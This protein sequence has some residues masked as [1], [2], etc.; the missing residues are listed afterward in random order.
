M[1]DRDD[2]TLLTEAARVAGR[3]AMSFWRA[4]PKAWEKSDGAGPV[5][6]ADMAVNAAVEDVL[7]HARPDYGWLSEESTDGPGR[8]QSG[9]VF[10]IDPIDGTRA[11]I[12]QSADFAHSFAVAEAGKVRAAVVFLP[13]R[14]LLYTATAGG[15]ALLNGAPIRVQP[16]TEVLTNKPAMAAA[17]WRDGAVPFRRAFRSSLAWRLALVAEGRF[18]GALTLRPTWEWDIAAGALLVESAG[19][20]VSDRQGAPLCF[21]RADPRLDGVIAAAP[22]MYHAIHDGLMTEPDRSKDRT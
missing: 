16:G 4:D 20:R 5:T 11:F 17:H 1:P 9:R 14:G 18:A 3:I 15:P 19:G 13:A 12:E 21:N 10:I 22:E 6:E 2:L 8:L 7:R